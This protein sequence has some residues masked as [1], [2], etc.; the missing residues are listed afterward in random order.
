MLGTQLTFGHQPIVRST[1]HAQVLCRIHT[2][3]GPR[4]PMVKLQKSA[5]RAAL[6]IVAHERT[7]VPIA[8]DDLTTNVMRNVRPA[9]LVC[10]TSY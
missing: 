5:G 4:G 2:A 6:T 3:L 9:C 1:K 7:T 10:A 8:S